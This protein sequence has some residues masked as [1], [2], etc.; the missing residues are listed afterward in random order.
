MTYSIANFNFEAI[1]NSINVDKTIA[2]RKKAKDFVEN[3]CLPG[4]VAALHS[5]ESGVAFDLKGVEDCTKEI[6]EM[7]VP[8]VPKVI[9]TEDEIIVEW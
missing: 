5:D 8:I 1:K 4:V 7:L 6:L 2:L 9:K 3:T